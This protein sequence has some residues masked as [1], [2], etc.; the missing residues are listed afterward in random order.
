MSRLALRRQVSFR[1]KREKGALETTMPNNIDQEL[2]VEILKRL[3]VK[4][5]VQCRCVSKSWYFLI[6][7]PSFISAH[8]R[9]TLESNRST[10]FLLRHYNWNSKKENYTLHPDDDKKGN[11]F[12]ECQEL[13]FPFKSY[14]QYFEIVG[15]CN[16]LLCLSDTYATNARTI[17]LWNPTIS[18]W[19]TL[20]MPNVN[21]DHAYMF[22]LGFGFDAKI[23]D[24]KV[25]R[26]VYGMG[27]EG[28]KVVAAPKVELYELGK[29]A[30]RNVNVSKSLRYVTSE[31]SLQ[32]FL[33]GAVHWIG[34]NPS[35]AYNDF[36][37]LGLVLFDM[38]DEIFREQKLPESVVGLSV[39]DLSIGVSRQLLFLIQYNRK[40]HSQWIRY[41]SCCIWVMKEYSNVESWTKQFA[42]NLNGGIGKALGLRKSGEIVLVASNGEL[43]TYEVQSDNVHHL[44]IK[45]I[46][47]S[48]YMDPYFESLVLLVGINGFS[49]QPSSCNT[50]TPSLVSPD[51]GV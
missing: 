41:D 37:D 13:A 29:N 18:K 12:C 33:N 24:Y 1:R 11:S 47:N 26:I 43:V 28:R 17:I 16:G 19:M 50:A 49:R 40:T 9:Y 51:Y 23:N 15:S 48:F 32:V 3:A 2:L 36:G 10:K 5:L 38:S 7:S 27:D 35:G 39:L 4:L 22:V 14:S 44:G 20:P 45:G 46:V 30:W 31:L 8:T 6:S 34:Y 21:L 42:V 25:V